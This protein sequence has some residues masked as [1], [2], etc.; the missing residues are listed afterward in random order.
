VSYSTPEEFDQLG[1]P[2]VALDGVAD[3]SPWRDAAAGRI[4]T[5]LRGRYSLPLV[6]P[7]P[8]EI[9]E[10]ECAIA[11]YLFLSRRGF[12]P[13]AG[14]NQNVVTRYEDAMRWLRDLA[15]GVLNLSLASDA[16]PAVADGGP[17]VRSSARCSTGRTCGPCYRDCFWEECC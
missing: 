8:P 10:A 13:E 2:A 16:T 7:Y 14:A 4:N 5:Y 3:T 15:A 6:A 17:I 11:A 1:L 9:I 12:D